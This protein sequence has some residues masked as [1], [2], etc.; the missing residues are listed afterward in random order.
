MERYPPMALMEIRIRKA[1][2]KERPDKATD[3]EGPFLLVQ[4]KGSKLWRLPDHMIANEAHKE[5]RISPKR[6]LAHRLVSMVAHVVPR[7]R[8]QK[9][10]F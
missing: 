2:A 5:D 7:R 6:Y 4:P 1:K 9:T 10:A 3:G 8:N